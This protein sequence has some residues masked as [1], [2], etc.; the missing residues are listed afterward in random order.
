MVLW[1]TKEVD[2][3]AVAIAVDVG[4]RVRLELDGEVCGGGV[5]LKSGL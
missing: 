5:E 4:G 3:E 1:L 2:Y